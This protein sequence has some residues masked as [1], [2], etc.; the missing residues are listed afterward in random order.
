MKPELKQQ[1]E[2]F[3]LK[4]NLDLN[5]MLELKQNNPMLNKNEEMEN[6]LKPSKEPNSPAEGGKQQLGDIEM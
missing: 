1:L 4:I 2:D 5:S 6:N 3:E